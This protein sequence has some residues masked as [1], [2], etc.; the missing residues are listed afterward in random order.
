MVERLLCC[1]SRPRC[2]VKA[3]TA[4]IATYNVVPSPLLT[5]QALTPTIQAPTLA[6]L[7]MPPP[8]KQ[9]LFSMLEIVLP[10]NIT[11]YRALESKTILE[12]STIVEAFPNL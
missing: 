3:I 9:I 4:F 10:N 7:P 8:T 2:F 12:L 11:I 5:L 6:S 1:K